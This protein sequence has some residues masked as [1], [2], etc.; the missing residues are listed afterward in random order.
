VNGLAFLAILLAAAAA[1]DGV[2][3]C[4]ER[5]EGGVG[6]T[7][8]PRRDIRIGPVVFFGLRRP[9]RQMV[10][11]THGRDPGYKIPIAVR[12]GRAV[13]LRIPPEARADVALNYAARN[14]GVIADGQWLVLVKPCP[15]R[16]RRFT[17]GKP[18]GRWTAF[19]G[20]L[21]VRTPGCYPIEV[22][23]RGKPFT[24]RLVALG[25]RC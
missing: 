25:R 21:I 23:R 22:A 9:G 19:S 2:R 6:V 14:A 3:R 20:G 10:P 4:S 16:T 8:S 5:V 13:L 18:I 12:A 7:I 15:P 24:R 11:G 1:P 17:N